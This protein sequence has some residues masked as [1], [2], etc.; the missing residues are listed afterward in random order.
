MCVHTS[1]YPHNL[2]ALCNKGHTHYQVVW[3]V[4]PELPGY[5]EQLPYMSHWNK[6]QQHMCPWPSAN[7]QRWHYWLSGQSFSHDEYKWPPAEQQGPTV[8][9]FDG[10][11][12][13][14]ENVIPKFVR[15]ELHGG[16]AWSTY[17]TFASQPPTYATWLCL[18]SVLSSQTTLV[19]WGL[20]LGTPRGMTAYVGALAKQD[21]VQILCIDTD[22]IRLPTQCNAM[23]YV[24]HSEWC[25]DDS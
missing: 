1:T 7:L 10:W 3:G 20:G 22:S 11:T 12:A 15:W 9:H 21:S 2:V 6:Q 19:L 14:R 16:H 25:G 4:R 18:W 17:S 24:C 23:L 8:V 5:E 13:S